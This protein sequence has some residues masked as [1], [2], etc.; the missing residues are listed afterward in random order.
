MILRR[1]MSH[2]SQQNWFAV[3]LDF[4][5]VVL[6]VAVGFQ[7]TGYYDERQRQAAESTYLTR[8][9]TDYGIYQTLLVCRTDNEAFLVTSLNAL[10]AEIDG[11]L[12]PDPNQRA[13]ILLALNLS[14]VNQPGLAFDGNTS[15]LAGEDLVKT[16]RDDELRGW[17][18]SAQSI[19]GYAETQLIQISSFF[20]T[21]PR[22]DAM[23]TRVWDEQFGG[24]TISDYDIAAMRAHPTLRND[25]ISL[26]NLHR[27]AEITDR[28]L[29]TSVTNVLDRLVELD[30]RDHQPAQCANYT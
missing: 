6:G 30:V 9:S 8:F 11:S 15:S 24:W 4:I 2:V 3:V 12:E 13:N 18:L 27:A 10:I 17:I 29:L 22:F 1:R 25:L 20:V 16:V 28:R 19:A 5:I 26:V 21:I 14:H 23:T 7:L